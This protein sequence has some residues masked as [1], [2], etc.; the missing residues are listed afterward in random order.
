MKKVIALLS[1]CFAVLLVSFTTLNNK[2]LIVI[3]AG[4]GGIDHGATF[5]EVFEKD[6][7]TQISKKIFEKHDP[8]KVEILLLRDTDNNIALTDR[9]NRINELKPDLV[10]SLHVNKVYSN[11]TSSGIEA[12][13][14]EKNNNHKTSKEQAEKLLNAIANDK[15]QSRGVKQANF[16]ILR[17][18]NCPSV[19]LELGFISNENDRNYITSEEGQYEIA[20]NIL[21][22]I[23]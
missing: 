12:Y 8:S 1:L 17:N 19:S 4:H 18:S 9:I 15:L 21:K 11:N 5:D 7:V 20:K 22:G 10:I 6:I 2:K 13:V 3:D 23:Q 16:M 14:S